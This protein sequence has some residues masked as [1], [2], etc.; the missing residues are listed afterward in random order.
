MTSFKL[1]H[2]WMA[3]GLDKL[4]IS[5]SAVHGAVFDGFSFAWKTT[6]LGSTYFQAI[7]NRQEMHCGRTYAELI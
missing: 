1:N 2:I 6:I 5:P 4:S 3:I 7:E